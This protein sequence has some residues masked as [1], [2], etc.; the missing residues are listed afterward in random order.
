MALEDP[1]GAVAWGYYSKTR[2]VQTI[3][4]YYLM[5][6][7]QRYSLLFVLVVQEIVCRWFLERVTVYKCTVIV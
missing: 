4:P 5:P 3:Y 7:C 2:G 1:L 6:A